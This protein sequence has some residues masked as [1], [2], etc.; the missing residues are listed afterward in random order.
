MI[1]WLT[2]D[3]QMSARGLPPPLFEFSFKYQRILFSREF[4]VIRLTMGKFPI[5][6]HR[7]Y[8]RAGN[9]RHVTLTALK[10]FL[11]K[12]YE[13]FPPSQN[14]HISV[15]I[16]SQSWNHFLGMFLFSSSR[17]LLYFFFYGF[18]LICDFILSLLLFLPLFVRWI[19]LASGALSRPKLALKKIHESRIRSSSYA[20]N[21]PSGFMYTFESIYIYA[22]SYTHL[23]LPTIYSV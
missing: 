11:N 14:R 2:T 20:Y 8:L 17:F 16:H 21:R 10:S 18:V 9:F 6:K 7:F 19:C 3:K 5:E 23:T 12:F 13:K 15:F 22:V 1:I 4:Q